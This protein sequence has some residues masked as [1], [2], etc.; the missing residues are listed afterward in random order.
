MAVAVAE[1]GSCS[2]D[3]TPS[4]G[5]SICRGCGPENKIKKLKCCCSQRSTSLWAAKTCSLFCHL[6]E[7]Q[8]P[9]AVSKDTLQTPV[10][11]FPP[12][13]RRPCRQD[14]DVAED[15]PSPGAQGNGMMF[16][17][18]GVCEQ[19]LA[20]GALG[21]RPLCLVTSLNPGACRLCSSL[22]GAPLSRLWST[23]S[24]AQPA[25]PFCRSKK[26]R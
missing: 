13:I 1:A 24:L 19:L 7:R 25:R 15:G 14:E 10:G 8:E 21:R 12:R 3:W 5:T 16:R 20:G 17:H 4:L 26:Q 9:P 23:Q 18:V 6:C 2:S 22:A 11:I